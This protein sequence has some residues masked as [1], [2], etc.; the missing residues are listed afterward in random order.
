M[1]G[2]ASC[3]LAGA[4]SGPDEGDVGT[5]DGIGIARDAEAGFDGHEAKFLAPDEIAQGRGNVQHDTSVIESRRRK[6]Y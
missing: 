4:Q 1:P 3:R 6:R 5:A 2:G